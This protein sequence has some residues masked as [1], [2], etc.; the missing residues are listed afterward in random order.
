MTRPQQRTQLI[1]ASRTENLANA[2]QNELRSSG[3]QTQVHWPSA[4]DEFGSMLASLTPEMVL[5]E[6]RLKDPAVEDVIRAV[7]DFDPDLPVLVMGDHVTLMRTV[8]ALDLGARDFVSSQDMRHLTLVVRRELECYEDRRRMHALFK[9]TQEL[10]TRARSLLKETGDAVLHVVEGVITEINPAFLGLLGR[11]TGDEA[12]IGQPI[13]DV[14]APDDQPSLKTVL[15]RARKSPN[16]EIETEIRLLG[17]DGVTPPVQLGVIAK[18]VDDELITECVIRQGALD[19]AF[20]PG[21]RL[22]LFKRLSALTPSADDNIQALVLIYVDQFDAL[23]E[24][25]GYLDSD[26]VLQRLFDML[27]PVQQPGDRVF[28]FSMSELMLL[29]RRPSADDIRAFADRLLEVVEQATFTTAEHETAITATIA[30]YPLSGEERPQTLIRDMRRNASQVSRRGGNVSIFMGPTAEAS[31]RKRVA[32]QQAQRIREA[33]ETDQLRL[34]FQPIA[35]LEGEPGNLLDTHIRMLTP[36]GGELMA[37][38]FLPVAIEYDLMPDID[39]W[40]MEQAVRTL[41][42]PDNAAGLHP[43]LFVRLSNQTLAEPQRVIETWREAIDNDR[44]KPEQIVFEIGESQIHDHRAKFA[45]LAD[46]I[47]AGGGRLAIDRFGNKRASL[48]LLTALNPQFIKLDPAFTRSLESSDAEVKRQFAEL[49]ETAQSQ[50]IRTIAEHVEDAN[51]MAQLWQLG[52]NYVQ[53]NHV[54][55]TIASEESLADAIS[56]V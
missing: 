26:Q 5:C 40:V 37:M 52:I 16:A 17:R 4:G 53:G 47:E 15:K 11:T 6:E 49:I 19:K 7:R 48:S 20:S 10:E 31:E 25:I 13:L 24:R 18:T 36:D 9:R 23:E 14:A 43:T 21:S 45:A 33:L 28:R 32:D 22:D 35:S 27:A 38:D 44:C 1:V 41:A 50:G 34:V 39:A 56:L 29:V 46:Q 54:Q 30:S 55:S 3:I 12:L 2:I 51:S 8:G 42:S